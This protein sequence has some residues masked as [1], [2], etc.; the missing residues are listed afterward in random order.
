MNRRLTRPLLLLAL[1][2]TGCVIADD[3]AGPDRG[4]VLR[5]YPA[6]GVPL[7]APAR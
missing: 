2:H 7:P 1:S 3:L 5:P 6:G 4:R